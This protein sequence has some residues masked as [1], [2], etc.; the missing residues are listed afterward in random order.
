LH[1]K[2][3][4]IIDIYSLIPNI[5]EIIYTPPIATATLPYLKEAIVLCEKLESIYSDSVEQN[6][7]L[8]RF[9]QWM[10][11]TT[12]ANMNYIREDLSERFNGRQFTI[13]NKCFTVNGMILPSI[14]GK[15][16][17]IIILCNAN[18]DYY[19]YIY[20]QNKWIIPFFTSKGIDVALWNYRG[21]GN[22]RGT[23]SPANLKS[24]GI[25]VVKHVKELGYTKI[26]V[27]GHSLGGDIAC[28]IVNK[29]N[30]DFISRN[31][32]P[33]ELSYVVEKI[34]GW[35]SCPYRDYSQTTSY[36]VMTNDCDDEMINDQCSLK[37]LVAYYSV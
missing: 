32:L 12:I 20:Y 3:I 17:K 13:A 36:K 26:G 25:C 2:S 7:P 21:Y 23:I 37:S 34:T 27:F 5:N 30:L 19:E 11:D 22:S 4:S 10:F 16:K 35:S 33:Y 8:Y 24:D 28:T 31:K 1:N 29:C 15:S 9:H 18:G 6:N 14:N